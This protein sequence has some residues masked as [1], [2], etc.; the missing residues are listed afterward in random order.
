MMAMMTVR[1]AILAS[2][3]MVVA[4]MLA[5]V[6]V[7]AAVLVMVVVVAVVPALPPAAQDS[8]HNAHRIE[9]LHLVVSHMK[10]K[11]CNPI[12]SVLPLCVLIIR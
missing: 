10:N 1:A 3:V 8:Y 6:V 12:C 9:P 2:V 7:V 4:L 5:I 11:I